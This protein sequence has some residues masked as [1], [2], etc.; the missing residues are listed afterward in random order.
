MPAAFTSF[1]STESSFKVYKHSSL[2][3]HFTWL[4][5]SISQVVLFMIFMNF[6]IAVITDSFFII[7]KEKISY[8]YLSRVKMIFE[9][10]AHFTEDDFSNNI[11]FPD[12]LVCQSAKVLKE[13]Q[14][15]EVDQEINEM[16]ALKEF[17][18]E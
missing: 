10:E 2:I 8:D 4:I 14:V 16:E 17:I 9:R 6:I 1:F 18:H 7:N 13:P 3:V 15:D 12:I 11:Y 5:Y